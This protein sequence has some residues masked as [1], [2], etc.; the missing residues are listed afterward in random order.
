MCPHT[1]NSQQVSV[2]TDEQE[3]QI[4]PQGINIYE[5]F[6]ILWLQ[7]LNN[8]V[9]PYLVYQDVNV[10]EIVFPNDLVDQFITIH[11]QFIV[12]NPIIFGGLMSY[13]DAV[14]QDLRLL[15]HHAFITSDT[16]WRYHFH[17]PI[18]NGW[19]YNLG[20]AIINE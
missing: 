9:F 8:R 20:F 2:Q 3:P 5:A 14:V 4:E 12:Q 13:V 18:L 19:Q 10:R 17:Q 16:N 11:S 7:V 6:R 15:S 1:P